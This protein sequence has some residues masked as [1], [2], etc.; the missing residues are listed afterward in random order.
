MGLYP[1]DNYHFYN[2]IHHNVFEDNDCI[3]GNERSQM[4]IFISAVCGGAILSVGVLLI[5]TRLKNRK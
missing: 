5:I 4:I 2:K 3:T 1:N